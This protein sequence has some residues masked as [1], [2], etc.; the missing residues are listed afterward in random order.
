[1]LQLKSFTLYRGPAVQTK[2]PLLTL[3]VD[4]VTW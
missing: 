4:M 1:M 2:I 3:E